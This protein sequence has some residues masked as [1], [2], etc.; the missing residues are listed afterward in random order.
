MQARGVVLAGVLGVTVVSGGWLL[1]RGLV[2]NEARFSNAQLFDEVANHV[3]RDYVDS[4]PEGQLYDKAMIGM[5]QELDDPYSL[6]LSPDRLSRLT[7]RTTGNYVGI[8]AQVQLRDGWPMIISPFPGSPAE[9]AGLH[10]GDRVVLIDS[11]R[12]KG[13]T[14]DETIRALR[15]PPGTSVHVVIERPGN[16]RQLPFD[17]QRG[18]I[19]RRAVARTMLL[20]DGVGFVDLNIFN[21]STE[22]ELRQAIDSLTAI[23][24]RSLI[25]DL[26]GNPGGVLAQGVGVAD[27]FLDKGE[28]IVSMRGRAPG[29]TQEFVD[30]AAQRWPALPLAVLVDGGSASAAE[31]VA[32]ALQDHDRAIVLGRTT[33]GKGSAQS[34]Y[35]V[36]SGGAVKLTT[37]RWYTPAGRS[38][39]RPQASQVSADPDRPSDG[40][41]MVRTEHG[42]SVY[43][44]GGIVPDIAVGDTALRPADQALQDALGSRVIDFRDAMVEYAIELKTRRAVSSPA[45]TVT[46]AMLDGLWATMRARGFTFPR[47]IYDGTSELVSRLL[48]RE[49]ARYTF[50]PQAEAERAVGD[51][52]VI[53]A[54]LR[55]AARA[56]T[57]NDLV[58]AAKDWPNEPAGGTR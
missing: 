8:G 21:D 3:R 39:N 5:L 24:M 34:V 13:W 22:I 32:G 10:T 49:I 29:S 23:G 42:R 45:F 20:H 37:A 52:E 30:S 2:G 55:L 33:F 19:H 57:P 48:A 51:D 31:I 36:S 47:R 46:P 25:L 53:Q 4:I 54:A 38:I 35:P 12:T 11:A 44:G 28:L 58:A 6:Y 43:G 7:E 41:R 18:G 50:G 16:A 9:R 14:V 1:R 17:L 40:R 26:R 56:R 15:G 27:M